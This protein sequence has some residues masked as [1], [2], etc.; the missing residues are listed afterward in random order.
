MKHVNIF[1]ALTA[2]S[3]IISAMGCTSSRKGRGAESTLFEKEKGLSQHID[4]VIHD[5]PPPTEVPFI[6][7]SMG[8][9]FMDDIVNGLDHIEQYKKSNSKLAMNL[10][11]YSTDIGYLACYN[12]TE[13]ALT[14][15]EACQEIAEY[16]GISTAYGEDLGE[17]FKK[18]MGNIDSLADIINQ[19]MGRIEE[20]LEKLNELSMASLSLTGS[21]VE[22][23]YII[24]K[25]IESHE[26]NDQFNRQEKQTIIAPLINIIIGQ[27]VPLLDN[28]SMLKSIER[29]ADIVF[30]LDNL[31]LLRFRYDDL[32]L[33]IEELN[34][35]NIDLQ[36]PSIQN[37]LT[38]IQ[39]TRESIVAPSSTLQQVSP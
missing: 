39:R 38:E 5:L 25:I 6:L 15:I 35:G 7:R 37:L 20:R 11:I 10:G 9:D 26:N 13:K 27:K 2:L 1:C 21:F 34:N 14:Y 17:R 32:E 4:K 24:T 22:G 36:H 30:I 28:I 31:N 3:L 18:N 29:D 16:I 19:G 12:H 33:Y 8:A 23:L